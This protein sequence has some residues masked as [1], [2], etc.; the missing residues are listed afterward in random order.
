[1]DLGDEGHPVG[2]RPGGQG[3]KVRPVRQNA[4]RTGA[5]EA[6]DAFEQS[7][8]AHAVGAQNGQQLPHFG[9]EG[10]LMQHLPAAVAEGQIF[11]GQ[12]HDFSSFR[13]M[14]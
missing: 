4:T 7:G 12:T 8:L 14:R 9:R 5:F 11:N 6:H 10:D 13:V 1:M 3:R 2:P